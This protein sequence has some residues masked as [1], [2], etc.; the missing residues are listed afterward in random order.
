M[1]ENDIDFKVSFEQLYFR[2]SALVANVTATINTVLKDEHIASF[3]DNIIKGDWYF[4]KI[5]DF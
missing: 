4:E 2:A 1:W 5:T 3:T